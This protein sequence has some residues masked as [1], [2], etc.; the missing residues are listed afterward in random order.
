MVQTPGMSRPQDKKTMEQP[1]MQWQAQYNTE[2][3]DGIHIHIIHIH[4]IDH[5]HTHNTHTIHIIHI[6]IIH[7][8]IIHINT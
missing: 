6:Q 1:P 8:H 3:I 4:I 5:T 2:P 7:I